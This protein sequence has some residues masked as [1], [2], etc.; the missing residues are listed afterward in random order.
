MWPAALVTGHWHL[1]LFLHASFRDSQ[2]DMTR[3]GRAQGGRRVGSLAVQTFMQCELQNQVRIIDIG[4]S[5]YML[6][7]QGDMARQ[8]ERSP[9]EGDGGGGGRA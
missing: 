3:Q 7:Q 1:Q 6:V 2:G 5:S 9:G 4:N 8:E